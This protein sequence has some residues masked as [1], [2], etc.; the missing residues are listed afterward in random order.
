MTASPDDE[1][2]ARFSELLSRSIHDLRNPLSVV[3]S[4]LEWLEAELTE[5]EDV[6]DAVRD[7]LTATSGI[8]TILQDLE[9]LSRIEAGAAISRGVV[10]VGA[11]LE[12]I[13]SAARARLARGDVAVVALATGPMHV[14]GD[15]RLVER[16]LEVLVEVSARVAPPASCVEIDAHVHED[17]GTVEITI[18]LR[19]TAATEGRVASIEALASGGI[20]VY[21]ALRVAEVHGGSL[22][23]RTTTTTREFLGTTVRL[24]LA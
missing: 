6:G 13:A 16:A 15:V 1:A 12:R 4:S 20:G 2:R 19:G 10:D 18:G 22:V 14:P 7:A 23:V 8:L 21:L 3:R 9:R 17:E 5:R 24:P 11:T